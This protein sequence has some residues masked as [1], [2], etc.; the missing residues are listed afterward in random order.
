MAFPTFTST[1]LRNIL[2]SCAE[3]F[4]SNERFVREDRIIADILGKF[5]GNSNLDSVL[6]KTVIINSLYATAIRNTT[7]MA[8]H[9]AGLRIDEK[10]KTGDVTIVQDIR[11]GHGLHHPISG[12]E[13]DLYSFATKYA[14][15]HRPRAFPLFDNLV[16]RFLTA[17]NKTLSFHDRFTQLQLRD[18]NKYKSVIDSLITFTQLEGFKYKKFDQGIWVISKYHYNP[19]NLSD[20]ESDKIRDMLG[21]VEKS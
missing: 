6:V 10:L 20:L 17:L 11:Q 3:L 19:I 12:K 2:I 1:S 7:A 18:F 5:V 9:I 14:A 4:E 15:L 16:M 21:Q 13:L 8:K